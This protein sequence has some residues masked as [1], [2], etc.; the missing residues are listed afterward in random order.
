[1]FA[2]SIGTMHSMF[3]NIVREWELPIEEAV[4]VTSH[5]QA[6]ELG[7]EDRVGSIEAG[8]Q[9]DFVLLDDELNLELV[10][11]AGREQLPAR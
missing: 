10:V 9:A 3:R 6:R 4:R 11:K 5:N 7:M 1:V 2:G 8:K